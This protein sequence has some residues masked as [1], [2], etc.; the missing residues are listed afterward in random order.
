MTGSFE[1]LIRN[2][3]DLLRRSDLQTIETSSV[4]RR[5]AWVRRHLQATPE[6]T[7][8]R[9]RHAYELLFF[10]YMHLR[11]ED[12]PVVS[13]SDTKIVWRSS[14]ACPTLE[15]CGRLGLDTRVVC[16]AVA[17]KPAQA[18]LSTLDPQ[19]RFLRSYQ[20]IRPHAEICLE[21]IERVDFNEMLRLARQEVL[22]T[23]NTP[24]NRSAIIAIGNQVLA[25]ARLSEQETQHD[26][27][28]SAKAIREAAK[29]LGDTNLSGAVLFTPQLPCPA[30]LNLAARANLTAV[31][32]GQPA[33]GKDTRFVSTAAPS[34]NHLEIITLL[35]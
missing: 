22:Q 10:D 26:Q 1:E 35:E 29:Q 6:Q 25:H 34:Q 27:H 2:Q 21:W 3:V 4:D 13:E 15:A 33:A 8:I 9:P 31:V 18:F 16:R 30:C 17:E 14:N 23:V 32:H 19:L 7:P 12:V 20:H 11:P 5:G 28:T 24:H